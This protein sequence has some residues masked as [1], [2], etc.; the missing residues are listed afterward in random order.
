M[1]KTKF[2]AAA[3]QVAPE[4][5]LNIAKTVDKVC[6]VTA[7]AADAGAE[8]IVFPECFIPMFPNF[9]IDL[10]NNNE[11]VRNLTEL[12]DNAITI[13]GPE[14]EQIGRVARDKRVY[15]VIGVN[16]RVKGNDGTLYNTLLFIG[17]DGEVLGKHRKLFPT[18]REKVFH[19]RGDASG[20]KV[21]D[22]PLGRIGGLICYEH[23]QPLLKYALISQGEQIHFASWPGWPNF[24]NG[25]SNKN[26]IDTASRAY[27]LEGQNFVIVSSLYVPESAKALAN[28]GNADWSF[29]GGSGIINPSGEWIAGPVYDQETIVYGEIDLDQ[30]KLRKATV[31]TTGRDSN[32]G[33]ISL[34]IDPSVHKPI[35]WLQSSNETDASMLGEKLDTMAKR[36]EELEERL[37]TETLHG[38]LQAL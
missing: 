30:I 31:D 17:P 36:I 11:W 28:L 22:T 16:E 37:R 18:N 23:L 4:F 2:I 38:R 27:A 13:P 3:V 14:V 21:Y 1:P 20:L 7:Q 8:M 34:N 12:F 10:Q 25:R 29:F 5:P 15:V 35:H 9:S 6:E 19:A 26:V 24:H 32:W 33:A